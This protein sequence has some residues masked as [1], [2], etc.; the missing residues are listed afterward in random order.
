MA[1]AAVAL[2]PGM[3]CNRA[4]TSLNAARWRSGLIALWRNAAA[5]D[6]AGYEG[7]REA[8]AVLGIRALVYGRGQYRIVAPRE[9]GLPIVY[10]SSR[11]IA[12]SK[13]EDR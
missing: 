8:L 6:T 10:G 12:E 4:T 13:V 7:K 2:T 11:T 9:E 5:L 3:V 1:A